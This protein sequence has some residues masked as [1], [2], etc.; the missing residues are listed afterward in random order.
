MA[1]RWERLPIFYVDVQGFT[2][3]DADTQQLIV[4][5]VQDMATE[6]ARPF[7]P[8]GEVW[9]TW[10][11]HGTGDGYYFLLVGAAPQEA[12][13]YALR[14]NDALAVHNAQH[15]AALPLRLY[16]ALDLG[17]VEL[18]GDQYHS[19]AFSRAARFLSHQPFKD[20]AGQQERPMALAM[21]AL[22]YTVWRE[23]S[24][25]DQRLVWTPFTFRDKHD[26]LHRGFV[27][28]AGWERS[29]AA[30]ASPR[31]LGAI[32]IDFCHRLGADWEDLADHLGMQPHEKARFPKGN[33]PRGV[34][35]WLDSRRRLHE[36]P[37]AV[38]VIGRADLLED[39]P[40]PS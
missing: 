16:G 34:W 37:D 23:D 12:L 29:A 15:G 8:N 30:Q 39:L 25:H 3:Y 40:H 35:E 24:A 33:E 27:L 10:R 36:L 32:K 4:R 11:R 1:E 17:T 14:V 13:A 5:R 6:A 38:R 20:Y 7:V 22:F 31:T 28:G 2:T 18:L 26:Y 19:E 21:S 9:H